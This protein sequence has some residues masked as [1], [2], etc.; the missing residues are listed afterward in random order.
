MIKLT[1]F[2]SS[3]LELIDEVVVSIAMELH[4][5]S[6][7]ASDKDSIQLNNLLDDAKKIIEKEYGKDEAKQLI[8]QIEGV[9]TNIV[10]LIK[11]RGGLAL[12]ITSNDVYYYH[13]GIA[14]EN[15][16]NVGLVPNLEP[17]I[18]NYQYTN[19]Y[20]LLILNR[21]D[22]R[23]FEGDAT[24]VKEI[25]LVGENAPKTL[26]IALG[27]ELTGTESY[28]GSSGGGE[29]GF[30]GHND[31][32]HEKDIDREN[33][34]R[35]VDQYIHEQYSADRELPLILY[36]LPENQ[37]IFRE[38][39]SN[40]YLIN[41]GIEESGANANFQTV[42]DKALAKNIEIV[43]KEQEK[44]F[45]RFRETTPKYRIDNQLDDLS[46]SALEGRIEELLINKGYKQNGTITDEGSFAE[47]SLDYVNQLVN[48]VLS[49][50][51]HVYVVEQSDM[52]VGINLSARLRY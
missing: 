18:E 32:N 19:Q 51:G 16:V 49:A 27:S 28:S 50:K 48:K 3:E 31:I 46:M 5:T 10:E 36:A 7:S 33:Y 24:S 11:Y 9:K 45:N 2:P 35:Q 15:L 38:L 41:D 17:L 44:M 1:T 52:P 4:S 39:S 43:K 47:S 37:A 42:Q 25:E 20:H 30:H 13:L 14:I 26:E 22:I 8:Q 6:V 34:F 40:K 21:E 23:L 29:A 12:Y